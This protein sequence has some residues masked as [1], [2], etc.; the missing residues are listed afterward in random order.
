MKRI[1]NPKLKNEKIT[2]I[3]DSSSEENEE[4]EENLSSQQDYIQEDHLISPEPVQVNH[5]FQKSNLPPLWN[6]V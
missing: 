6:S 5:E 4:S 2:I 3:Q 1:L